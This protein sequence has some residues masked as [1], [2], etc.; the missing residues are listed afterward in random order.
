MRP[1]SK[2]HS[3]ANVHAS[4]TSV[5]RWGRGWKWKAPAPTARATKR[6][7]SS[8]WMPARTRRCAAHVYNTASRVAVARSSPS[9]CAAW[10]IRAMAHSAS[11]CRA[12]QGRPAC[13]QLNGSVVTKRSDERIRCPTT[14]CQSVPGSRKS[15]LRPK[16]IT[17]S[18]RARKIPV[19]APVFLRDL[20]EHTILYN[21]CKFPLI[22]SAG[23]PG[24][25]T[26][27]I[28]PGRPRSRTGSSGR[29]TGKRGLSEC[30]QGRRIL[31]VIRRG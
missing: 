18:Q 16:T 1:A 7:A 20:A 19:S 21:S 28:W 23:P 10:W 5:A 13:V 8:Q 22:R 24:D 2:S 9:R 14:T 31:P 26:R 6:S 11:H 15:W 4:R 3:S 17:P 29:N 12:I 25:P 30:G 27:T